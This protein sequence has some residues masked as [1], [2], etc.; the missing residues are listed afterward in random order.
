MCFRQKPWSRRPAD[1][2]SDVRSPVIEE[3]LNGAFGICGCKLVNDV[4]RD[5]R[6]KR[7][8]IERRDKARQA[9]LQPVGYCP[10]QG[11]GRTGLGSRLGQDPNQKAIGSLFFGLTEFLA[12]A[13]P[14]FFRGSSEGEPLQALRRDPDPGPQPCRRA[15]AQLPSSSV[16]DAAASSSRNL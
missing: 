2:D 7:H 3:T 14:R 9:S 10:A 4:F 12:T 11:G 6:D 1:H 8:L 15:L 5:R 13:K 16:E